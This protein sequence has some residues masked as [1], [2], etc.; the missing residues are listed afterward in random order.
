M[1]IFLIILRAKCHFLEIGYNKFNFAIY[2]SRVSVEFII[3]NNIYLTI[4][5]IKV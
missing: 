1:T 5:V 3:K 4:L 2:I